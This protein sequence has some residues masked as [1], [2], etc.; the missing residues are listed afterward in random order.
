MEAN[1]AEEN[2]SQDV[3]VLGV[4]IIPDLT[5]PVESATSIYVDIITTELEERGSILKG[6]IECVLLPIIR[7][8]GELDRALNVYSLG[9]LTCLQCREERGYDLPRSIWL[10]NVRSSAVPMVNF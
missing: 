10:R 7:I 4:Q 1:G 8:I 2:G 6:L 5:V 3:D 9:Q